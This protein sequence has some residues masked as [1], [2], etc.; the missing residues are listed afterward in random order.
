MGFILRTTVNSWTVRKHNSLRTLRRRS[1]K[2]YAL[3]DHTQARKIKA[4]SGGISLG[5]LL[6]RG[7]L[8]SYGR[9]RAWQVMS[10]VKGRAAA[11]SLADAAVRCNLAASSGRFIW[12]YLDC[13]EAKSPTIAEISTHCN[14][15][16]K[17]FKTFWF[18]RSWDGITALSCSEIGET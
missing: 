10:S 1:K 5:M 9:S 14:V 13:L 16:E 15:T 4:I 6:I 18:L 2:V 12:I 11:R 3:L 7:T 8:Q 17:F